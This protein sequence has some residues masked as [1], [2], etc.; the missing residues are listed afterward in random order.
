MATPINYRSVLYDG[1]LRL[2]RAEAAKR[3]GSRVVRIAEIF[4]ALSNRPDEP[5]PLRSPKRVFVSYKWGTPEQNDRVEQ[6]VT[7]LE[8]RG[9]IVTF[10]N[11]EVDRTDPDIAALVGRILHCHYFLMVITPDYV[12]AISSSEELQKKDQM[13]SWKWELETGRAVLDRGWVYDEFHIQGLLSDIVRIAPVGLLL[14]GDALPVG[15]SLYRPATDGGS[16]LDVRTPEQLCKV[17][18]EFFANPVRPNLSEAE[19]ATKLIHR[20]EQAFE[21]DDFAS[22]LSRAKQAARIVPSLA[23]AYRCKSVAALASGK[24]EDAVQ[25]AQRVAEL[26]PHITESDYMCAL[27]TTESGRPDIATLICSRR[28]RVGARSWR[29]SAVQA[30]ALW[31]LEQPV[32]GVNHLAYACSQNHVLESIFKS[33]HAEWGKAGSKQ[34]PKQRPI[35]MVSAKAASTRPG[36]GVL[37]LTPS[38]LEQT[39]ILLDTTFPEMRSMI[40]RDRVIISIAV[41]HLPVTDVAALCFKGRSIGSLI[42]SVCPAKL[43]VRSNI[44]SICADCGIVLAEYP[45]VCPVCNRESTRALSSALAGREIECPYCRAGRL[46]KYVAE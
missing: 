14:E 46:R 17:L 41:H 5:Y 20:S 13:R 3:H 36:L 40:A 45:S 16:V 37:Q 39:Y 44:E 24:F 21:R 15:M 28:R 33:Y 9:N 29:L 32:A 42:C 26:E 31:C 25:A 43:P 38:H 30:V 7:E 22:A 11:Q 27:A 34:P 23:D 2:G 6:L 4:E 1:D 8:A 18:D 19:S 10:D 12:Q 35:P